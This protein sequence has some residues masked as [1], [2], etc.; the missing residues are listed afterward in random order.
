MQVHSICKRRLSRGSSFYA[1][2]SGTTGSLETSLIIGRLSADPYYVYFKAYWSSCWT[3][4]SLASDC[5]AGRCT[6]CAED[7][8]KLNISSM[9]NFSD[10]RSRSRGVEVRRFGTARQNV[11][12]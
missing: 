5:A 4:T 1:L 12:C 7:E 11:L 6:R 3:P 2:R 8:V 10:C 9:A